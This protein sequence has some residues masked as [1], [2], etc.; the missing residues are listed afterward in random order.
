MTLTTD[1]AKTFDSNSFMNLA[2]YDMSKRAADELYKKTGVCPQ[3]VGVCELHDCFSP[4]EL[5]TYEAIG[6][7]GEGKAGEFID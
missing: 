6:L 7:C 1:S 3:E 2:G 5:I 4:N